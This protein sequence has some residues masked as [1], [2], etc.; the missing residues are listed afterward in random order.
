MTLEFRID[1]IERITITEFGVGQDNGNDPKFTAVPGDANVQIALCEMARATWNAMQKHEDGPAQYQPSEKYGSTAYLFVPS[2]DNLD[3]AVRKLHEAQNLPIDGMA[4]ND[5]SNV[6]CYFFA[7]FADD[8]GRRLT[9]LR[10]ASH[11]K[12]MLKHRLARLLSDTL[13]IVEDKIFK[14]DTDFDLLVDSEYTYILRPSAFEFL[15][16]LKQAILDAVPSN[17][18]SIQEDMAFMDFGDVQNYASKRPRAARYLASVRT[19]NLGGITRE[20]LVSSCRAAGVKLEETAGVVKVA[21][22]DVMGFLEVLDRRRYQVELI[23]GT[24]EQFKAA[25]RSRID[26]R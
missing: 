21:D 26:G 20:A 2:N 4:L 8:Q 25:S 3:T 22:R 23:P 16:G 17:I 6:F 5:L 10:R 15:G 19:Q 7:R 12:G 18:V 14:L 1:E 13:T 9:A 11:F 24:P